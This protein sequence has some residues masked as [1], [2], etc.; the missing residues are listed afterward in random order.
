MKILVIAPARTSSTA[1]TAYLAQIKDN[2]TNFNEKIGTNLDTI[3]QPWFNPNFDELRPSIQKALEEELDNLFS[4]QDKFIVKF[5]GLHLKG[6]SHY[7]DAINPKRFDEVHLVERSNFLE[8]ACSRCVARNEGIWINLTSREDRRNFYNELSKKEKY[9][10]LT[11]D[12]IG[13]T[14]NDIQQYLLCKKYLQDNNI[15]YQQHY[16]ESPIFKSQ[17]VEGMQETGL[18]YSFLI[19]NYHWYKDLNSYFYQYFNYQTCRAD[20]KEF[21]KT[22]PD[23]LANQNNRD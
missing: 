2:L 12:H 10:E 7:I 5:L 15:T 6:L 19:K 14:A 8:Q 1:L 17:K 22:F 4:N 3:H 21:I 13:I 16:Y 23:Y 18:N 20:Y 11:Y 9:R